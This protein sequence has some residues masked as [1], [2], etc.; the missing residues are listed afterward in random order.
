[1]AAQNVGGAPAAATYGAFHV[2]E[3]IE[4]TAYKHWCNATFMAEVDANSQTALGVDEE[5]FL[6]Y[7]Q[8][9][10]VDITQFNFTDKL[11]KVMR[12]NAGDTWWHRVSPQVQAATMALN[13]DATLADA[14]ATVMVSH[15]APPAPTPPPGGVDKT[16]FL[17]HKAYLE[18]TA[19][20]CNKLAHEGGDALLAR[21]ETAMNVHR[22][23]RGLVTEARATEALTRGGHNAK[24]MGADR[25]AFLGPPRCTCRN[26]GTCPWCCRCH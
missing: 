14:M 8:S 21:L 2:A 9:G 15:G 12:D 6:H 18:V 24:D 3:G 19:K 20:V 16:W 4:T 5:C 17:L 7:C 22:A 1:M 25:D 26:H 13:V 11:G 23:R 10:H